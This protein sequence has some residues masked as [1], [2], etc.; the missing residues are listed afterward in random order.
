MVV[1]SEETGAGNDPSSQAPSVADKYRQTGAGSQACHCA[2]LI[3]I[4]GHP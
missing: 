1:G 4:Q 3:C 2:I